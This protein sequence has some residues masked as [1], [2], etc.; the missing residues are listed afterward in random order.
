MG[1]THGGWAFRGSTCSLVVVAKY[2]TSTRVVVVAANVVRLLILV[3]SSLRHEF[4]SLT[5]SASRPRSGT[6]VARACFCDLCAAFPTALRSNLLWRSS[7]AIA[8]CSRA[9]AFSRL[10]GREKGG[11]EGVVRCRDFTVLFAN[12]KR[13]KRRREARTRRRDLRAAAGERAP[14]LAL[15]QEA[16]LLVLLGAAAPAALAEHGPHRTRAPRARARKCRRGVRL[17]RGSH[18]GLVTRLLSSSCPSEEN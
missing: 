4:Q 5:R 12:E 18:C 3:S 9:S 6:D 11:R 13:L 1:V 15:A 17:D 10:S 16:S 14:N 7:A 2:C 8:A